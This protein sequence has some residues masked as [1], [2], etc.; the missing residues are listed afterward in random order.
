MSSLRPSCHYQGLSGKHY[1]CNTPE[2][3]LKQ[4]L[5]AFQL[6]LLVWHEWVYVSPHCCNNWRIYVLPAAASSVFNWSTKLS[7]INYPPSVFLNFP[8]YAWLQL[9]NHKQLTRCFRVLHRG[10]F[11]A[12]LHQKNSVPNTEGNSKGGGKKRQKQK[13]RGKE[14]QGTMNSDEVAPVFALFFNFILPLRYFRS[15]KSSS[16]EKRSWTRAETWPRTNEP[17]IT[18]WLGSLPAQHAG[19]HFFSPHPPRS[20][21]SPEAASEPPFFEHHRNPFETFQTI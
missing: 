13:K 18:L 1:G 8:A 2:G 11:K 14:G 9:F 20:C 3:S 15:A 6:I 17:K 5:P 16:S 21:I 19:G 10:N 4:T 12:G 7:V